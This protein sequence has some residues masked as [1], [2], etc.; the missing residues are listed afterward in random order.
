MTFFDEIAKY[1]RAEVTRKIYS[2]TDK[3]VEQALAAAPNVSI[4]QFMALIS[5]AADKYLEEM[6]QISADITLRRFG[7]TMQLYAPLYL[8]NF[9]TNKCAY[10][11][12]SSGNKIKR[13]ILSDEEII[14]EA[15][16]LTK[17][18]FKHILLVTGES[19]RKA[20]VEYLSNSI[21]IMSRYF[22]QVSLEVQ[23]LERDEY[24]QLID[25]GLHS[26]Y[27]YQ[28]TYDKDRYPL[29]HLAGKKR[30]YRFRLET[31]DRL[32]EAGIYKTGLANLIGLEEWRTEAFFT[33]LHLGYLSSK[34]WR[35]KYS[36]AFPRLR[37]FTG[38]DAF[39]ANYETSERNLLQMICAYRLLSEDV[40]LSLSTRESAYFRDNVMRLGITTMSAGSKT[41]PG[42]YSNY[43]QSK[44]LEQFEVNDDRGIY[45][46]SKAIQD[47]GLEPVWKDWDRSLFKR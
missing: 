16:A 17:Y 24:S 10:C 4:D 12:F 26:V 13:A 35:T 29:Y 3:E 11:G 5:P 14:A 27:I 6:A 44:E 34:Y 37:P 45:D 32:G 2:T 47:A 18:P 23:P 1:D 30:D 9:C 25:K 31:P 42:G 38:D 43:E 39:A 28:E 21:E 20:G 15:E 8:S 41:T 36:I 40:E 33:A 46:V 7:N 22:E 19:P